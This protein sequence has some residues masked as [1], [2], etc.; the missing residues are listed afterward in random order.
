MTV[1]RKSMLD[2]NL[3]IGGIDISEGGGESD[4]ISV[5]APQ[6]FDGKTGV[7]NDGVLYD[8]P[9][10]FYEATITLLETAEANSDLQGLFNAQ[11]TD[12]NQGPYTF[13]VEDI[14]TTEE[15]SGKAM[16]IKEPDRS[17]T[18]EAQNYEWQLKVFS[19]LGWQYRSRGA[20]V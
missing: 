4:F 18:A 7:H 5:T 15:L 14:G 8:T 20:V 10:A 12:Q 11:L 2:I 6:R 19:R 13:Q 17:K 16:I 3:V 1:V 9:D